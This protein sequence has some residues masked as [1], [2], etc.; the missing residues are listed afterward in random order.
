M[1][2]SRADYCEKEDKTGGIKGRN[3]KSSL[4][5]EMLLDHVVKDIWKLV[6]TYSYEYKENSIRKSAFCVIC[7]NLLMK[8][9]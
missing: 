7:L 2:L 5:F 3:N 8:L 9:G 6:R 1:E 4:V